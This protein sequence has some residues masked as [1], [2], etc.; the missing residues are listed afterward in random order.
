MKVTYH[1]ED[2]PQTRKPV[3]LTIGVFDGVHLGHQHIIKSLH[4]LTRKGGTKAL[5]TFTNH[6]Q[7][8]L[9][10]K[11]PTPLLTSFKH[12]LHLL[13]KY[14]IDLVIAASF[15][16]EFSE[17][18]YTS[19]LTKLH[20][21]LPFSHL[22]LGEGS[23]FGKNREGDASSLKELEKKLGFE[24]H[25]LKKENYHKEEIS[26]GRIRA[27]VEEGKLK[28][29][30]KCLDR[31]YS[32]WT[33]FSYNDVMK[34][35]EDLYSWTYSAENLCLLPSAVYGVDLEWEKESQPAIAFLRG[36]NTLNGT[37]LSLTVYF[38]KAPPKSQFLNISFVE[39]LHS[40]MNPELASSAPASI[41]QDLSSQL[42]LSKNMTE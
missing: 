32:I 17:Q 15:T 11:K 2:I 16:R 19:F 27:F 20:D 38:E 36:Q 23:A 42:S 14:G 12:R 37:H 40:E 10:S 35:T 26:S 30:K 3:V 29:A 21:K 28:K 8:I 9:S 7:H 13:E 22:V 5:F 39:Y 1:L 24:M 6:P 41:L 31:P 34:E 33:P 18:S 25:F 4:K